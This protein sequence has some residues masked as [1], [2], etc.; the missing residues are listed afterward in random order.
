VALT[1]F[2]HLSFPPLESRPLCYLSPFCVIR[3][4]Q[5]FTSPLS[6]GFLLRLLSFRSMRGIV[7]LATRGKGIYEALRA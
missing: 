4:N 7:V 1:Y 6:S 2:P 5:K 3:S